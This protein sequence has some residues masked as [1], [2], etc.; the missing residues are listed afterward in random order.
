MN[1]QQLVKSQIAFAHQT[2]RGIMQDVND[3]IAASVP[4][5]NIQ[6]I[7]PIAAHAVL[8][9]DYFMSVA[10]GS[11]PIFQLE[12][13]RPKL[14][15]PD[16][17]NTRLTDEV[18]AGTILNLEAFNEY[19]TKVFASTEGWLENA[20]ADALGRE[21]DTPFGKMPALA[22]AGGLVLYHI[23]EHSGEIAAIKGI[24]GMKGLPF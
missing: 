2:F 4:A 22:L 20:D 13:W 1:A 6:P 16:A 7:G 14:G 3:A 17:E 5:G 24:Q 18:A 9:E 10:M 23:S 12:G 11:S 8:S 19:A 15:V 21:V